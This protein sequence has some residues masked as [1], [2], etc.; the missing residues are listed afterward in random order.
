MTELS[1][2]ATLKKQVNDANNGWTVTF[3][4]SDSDATAMLVLAQLKNELLKV[5][6]EQ[7]EG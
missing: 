1:F 2:T 4:V 3:D 7:E 5:T 6:I